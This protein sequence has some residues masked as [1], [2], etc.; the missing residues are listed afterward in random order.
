MESEKYTL[1]VDRKHAR[2][3]SAAHRSS[4]SK[5]MCLMVRLLYQYWFRSST[6]LVTLRNRFFLS[7]SPSPSA[8]NADLSAYTMACLGE[9][10]IARLALSPLARERKSGRLLGHHQQVAIDD[11]K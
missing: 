10:E 2:V 9:C 6:S 5:H 1:G 4:T 8:P 3:S 11:F 7:V